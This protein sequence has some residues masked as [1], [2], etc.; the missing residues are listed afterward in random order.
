MRPA[1]R[2][3]VPGASGSLSIQ[4]TL[5]ATKWWLI[6]PVEVGGLLTIE[7][8]L[9]TGSPLSSISER[10][11]GSLAS[12]GVLEPVSGRSYVLRDLKIQNQPIRDLRVR[13]SRRVTRVGADGV[14]GL[15]FLAQYSA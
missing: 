5:H 6:V 2:R 13:V 12:M 10:L 9:D 7:M 11:R 8:V 3:V 4:T 15:D 14:L 1:P